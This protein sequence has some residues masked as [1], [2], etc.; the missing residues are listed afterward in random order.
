MGKSL[1]DR[2]SSQPVLERSRPPISLSWVSITGSRALLCTKHLSGIV[3]GTLL[4]S[5]VPETHRYPHASIQ[6]GRA[7]GQLAPGSREGQRSSEAYRRR[8]ANVWRGNGRPIKARGCRAFAPMRRLRVR[9]FA[10][11]QISRSLPR[12]SFWL[13]P[14]RFRDRLQLDDGLTHSRSF[15]FAPRKASIWNVFS[16]ESM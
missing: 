9:R 3:V 7:R 4:P 8:S 15:Y 16:R 2:S 5:R 10:T 14:C 6:R 11:T 1:R 13:H 12:L